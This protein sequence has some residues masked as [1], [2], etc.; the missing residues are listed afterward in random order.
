V[1]G[2]AGMG[3]VLSKECQGRVYATEAVREMIRSGF[4]ILGLKRI[5]ARC[6][7]ENIA[8]VSVTHKAGMKDEGMLRMRILHGA[9]HRDA[10]FNCSMPD[11]GPVH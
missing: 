4:L 6:R 10:A 7:S 5:E 11:P 2:F 8:S 1:H 3:D 9:A